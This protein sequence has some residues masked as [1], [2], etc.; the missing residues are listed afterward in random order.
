MPKAKV[1]KKKDK[2]KKIDV[3]ILKKEQD[4]K[5]SDFKKSYF[6]IEPFAR[7]EIRL[8]EG[9]YIYNLIEPD[10]K[11]YKKDFEKIKSLM[12]TETQFS[13]EEVPDPEAYLVQKMDEIARKEKIKIPD[14]IKPFFVYYLKTEFLGL[15]RLEPL[16]KDKYIED[17]S[18]NGPGVPLYIR[19]RVLGSLESNIS[20]PEEEL[21]SYIMRISQ[22]CKR[23]I[24]YAQ[25]L[26]DG[27]LPDGS[28]VQATF[29]G[30]VSVKGPNFTIRRFRSIP[31]S[32]LDMIEF[33]T[34]SYE[35]FAYFWEIIENGMSV[36]VSGGTATGKT[37]F[38]NSIALFIPPS[39]K[40]ISIEDTPEI[41][42]PHENWIQSVSRAGYGAENFGEISMFDLLKASFRQRPDYIILGEVRGQEAYVLFQSMASGHPGL[43]TIHAESVDAIVERLLSPPINLS[44]ALL[45]LLDVA[46]IL[47]FA[48]KISHN[49]R[50]IKEIVEIMSI[51]SENQVRSNTVYRWV[52]IDDVF[53]F[54]GHSHVVS[55]ISRMRGKTE[56][57]IWVEIKEKEAILKKMKEKVTNYQD[58]F[59]L[60]SL[61]YTEKS[62]LL[63]K[64]GM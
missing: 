19:H 52:P 34:G 33:N 17:V 42:I 27:S 23:F 13:V 12:I 30:G 39:L 36:L 57:E 5:A 18:C 49:A 21:N 11:E 43:G 29:G 51:S 35:L 58:F 64:L 10:L 3:P 40:V 8:V 62:A 4:E 63:K 53:D 26:L 7:I 31:L 41:N 6:V 56:D 60:M 16:L 32:P 47:V 38:L 2:V 37:S 59:N 24:S 25:P 61:Y 55:K 14:E 45:E 46:C 9:N 28:R 44:P 15:G 22:K 48:P 50:R 20:F 1:S 54:T